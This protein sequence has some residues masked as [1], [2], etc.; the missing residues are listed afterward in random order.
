[1]SQPPAG[2]DLV[3]LDGILTFLKDQLLSGL[4]GQAAASST[5]PAKDDDPA[6]EVGIPDTGPEEAPDEVDE[7]PKIKGLGGV[8]FKTTM[9]LERYKY[10]EERDRAP[11]KAVGFATQYRR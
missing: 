3:Q 7:K 2:L 4:S 10:N 5:P 9:N 1:M 8:D 6:P 11:P